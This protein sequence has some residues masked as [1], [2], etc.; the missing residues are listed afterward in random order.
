MERVIDVVLSRLDDAQGRPA[1]VLS[2]KRDITA[3]DRLERDLAALGS[4]VSA[5]GE[6]RSRGT[7]AARALEIAMASTGATQGVIAVSAGDHRTDPRR[8]GHATGG[9]APGR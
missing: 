7:L 9:P 3:S 1:G 6:A 8:P 5:T 2:V 4:L